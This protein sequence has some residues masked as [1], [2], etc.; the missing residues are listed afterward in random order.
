[1]YL[2]DTHTHTMDI[3]ICGRIKSEEL[4]RIYKNAG[5]SSI[6]ITDHFYRSYFER[7]DDLSWKKKIECYLQGFKSAHNEG[8]K[9][10]LNV[11]L[12]IE[13]R[14][15]GADEDFLIFGIDE[16]FLKEIYE[17]YGLKLEAYKKLA[18]SYGALVFQ[19]HP[20]RKG[21]KP[22]NPHFLDGV[23]IYNTNPRHNN[24][25]ELAHSYAKQ[26]LLMM[27]SGSDAHR[28]EDCACTGMQVK[29]NV[30]SNKDLLKILKGEGVI[31]VLGEF[32]DN[33]KL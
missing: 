14:F 32:S 30:T 3:S 7:L 5:Y 22:V 25:N 33:Y 4:V 31:K 13:L 8:E 2:I 12:G 9:I 1:M 27:S 20:F 23:E 18:N 29:E 26:N 16:H 15:D 10:G 6:V 19:A 11:L 21:N 17:P 28:L 24:H